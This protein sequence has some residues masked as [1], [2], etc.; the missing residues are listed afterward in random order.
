MLCY[1]RVFQGLLGRI[2]KVEVLDLR[3]VELLRSQHRARSRNADP[4]NEGLGIDLVVFHGV[5]TNE[6]AC[7]AETCFAVYGDGTCIRLGEVLLAACHELLNNVV[8][9]G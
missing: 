9:R 6:G 1:S 5:N 7:S 4:A 2:A 8:W 3:K